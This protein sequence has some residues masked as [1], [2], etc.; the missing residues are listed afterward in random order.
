MSEELLKNEGFDSLD[1]LIEEIA[2]LEEKLS[3]LESD[4]FQDSNKANT[5]RTR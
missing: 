4:G 3:G 1:D 2:K 5:V